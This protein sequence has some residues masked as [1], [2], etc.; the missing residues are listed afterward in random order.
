M[1]LNMCMCDST[2]GCSVEIQGMS[3]WT[4]LCKGSPASSGEQQLRLLS[5]FMFHQLDAQGLVHHSF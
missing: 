5:A 2:A 3:K 4:G 1:S